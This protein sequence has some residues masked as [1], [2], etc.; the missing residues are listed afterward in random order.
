MLVLEDW[1]RGLRCVVIW[2]IFIV[3]S[4]SPN[5]IGIEKYT[6]ERIYLELEH[7]LF[8]D[9]SHT[10]A[11]YTGPLV[12]CEGG[13]P[14]PL[15]VAIWTCFWVCSSSNVPFHIWLLCHMPNHCRRGLWKLGL[16]MIASLFG[17]TISWSDLGWNSLLLLWYILLSLFILGLL[18]V[19]KINLGFIWSTNTHVFIF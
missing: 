17:P 7:R 6:L 9:F 18:L 8:V 3:L 13:S 4:L 16:E 14:V 11:I 1:L 2:P 12:R 5:L 10:N 19:Q 15:I